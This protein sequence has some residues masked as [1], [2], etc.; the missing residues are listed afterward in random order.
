MKRIISIV[1]FVILLSNMLP[2][3]AVKAETV[4]TVTFNVLW[5]YMANNPLGRYGSFDGSIETGTGLT[6]QRTVAFDARGGDSITELSDRKIAWKSAISNAYD[7]LQV[8]LAPSSL[9]QIVTFK[10]GSFA[11]NFT[12]RELM[13]INYNTK[14]DSANHVVAIKKISNSVVNPKKFKVAVEW[15]RISKNPAKLKL[16]KVAKWSGSI[17][18]SGLDAQNVSFQKLENNDLVTALGGNK[19]TKEITVTSYTNRDLDGLMFSLPE[20]ATGTVTINLTS[21]VGAISQSFKVSELRKADFKKWMDSYG[22]GVTVK[23]IN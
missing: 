19:L 11:K 20:T 21:N 6:L 23:G 5:G 1:T 14:I 18:F 8:N 2:S 4:P 3:A 12:A 15:G 9:D 7:G 16:L 17:K 10:I 22:N 13:D